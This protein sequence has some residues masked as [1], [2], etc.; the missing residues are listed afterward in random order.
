MVAQFHEAVFITDMTFQATEA[1]VSGGDFAGTLD[2]I[3][4]AYSEKLGRVASGVVDFKTSKTIY[5][6][7]M[8]QLAAL[9]SADTIFREVPEGTPD[10]I[11]LPDKNRGDSWWI[12]EDAP[13][14]ETAW[15]LHLR[16]NFWDGKQLVPAKWELIELENDELHLARFNAYKTVWYAEKALKEAGVDLKKRLS[17]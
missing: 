16:G 11:H 2:A 10:A 3:A 17:A 15:I 9:R 5:A 12:V 1:T 14:T 8:M 4:T 6:D 13:E 7:P